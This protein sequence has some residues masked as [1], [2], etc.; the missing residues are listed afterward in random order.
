MKVRK[1][2]VS[3]FKQFD[4]YELD[5]VDPLTDRARDLVVLIGENGSGKT[6]L[7]QAL[8]LPLSVATRVRGIKRP[9][10]FQWPGFMLERLD[11]LVA[12]VDIEL[13]LDAAE[14]ATTRALAEELRR[15]G[16]FEG[17][18]YTAPGQSARVMLSYRQGQV[19]SPSFE[20]LLQLRGREYARQLV[21]QLGYSAFE[22]VGAIFWYDQERKATSLS[23]EDQQKVDIKS[24]RDELINFHTYH[25]GRQQSEGL[26][27]AR[28]IYSELDKLYQRVFHPR[29]LSGISVKPLTDVERGEANFWFMLTDGKKQYEIDEMSS[30]ERALFPIL[31]DFLKWRIHRSV[32]LIDELELHL[33]PPLQQRL[34]NILPTLGQGN[35]FIITT[36]S[37]HVAQLL[38]RDLVHRVESR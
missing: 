12:A 26:P 27:D 10:D 3:N 8:A 32:V 19:R 35:Q 37:E 36:H 17:M 38:P 21:K 13:E 24:L 1:L 22:E 2:R 7:L 18:A 16:R 11:P 29:R 34:L 30:G 5:L 4:E 6:T 9:E 20:E 28:D 15:L 31:F 23:R 25:L 14:I 33:H